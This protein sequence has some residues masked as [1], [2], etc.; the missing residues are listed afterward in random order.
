MYIRTTLGSKLPAF[1]ASRQLMTRRQKAHAVTSR[2]NTTAASGRSGARLMRVIPQREPGGELYVRPGTSALLSDSLHNICP[3]GQNLGGTNN[4]G[5]PHYEFW[6]TRPPGV[7]AYELL[8]SRKPLRRGVSH[9]DF[10][11]DEIIESVDRKLFSQ[12]TQPSHCLHHLLPPKTS[13]HCPYCLRK[14]QHYYQLPHVGYS[15]YIN[16]FIN[17]C[18]FNFR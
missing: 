16:S 4:I 12:I 10:D 14:R 8:L 18:L 11:I 7:Y 5:V 6:G 9:T 3:T 17:R 13:T 15:Q 1:S 2:L